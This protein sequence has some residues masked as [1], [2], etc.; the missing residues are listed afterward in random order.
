MLRR[1][2]WEEGKGLGRLAQGMREPV[3]GKEMWRGEEGEEGE[4]GWETCCVAG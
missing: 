2:G 3:S 1:M 4:G